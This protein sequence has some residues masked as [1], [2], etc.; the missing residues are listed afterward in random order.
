MAKLFEIL[1]KNELEK[2]PPL[3]EWIK[4]TM[5]ILSK[6]KESFEYY[7][8]ANSIRFDEIKK[9]WTMSTEQ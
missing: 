5:E 8:F 9:E 3:P 6:D 7:E 1:L 2:F 4:Q